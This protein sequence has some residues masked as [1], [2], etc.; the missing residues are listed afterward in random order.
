MSQK[1]KSLL[2]SLQLELSDLEADNLEELLKALSFAE[3][4]N[5]RAAATAKQMD[6]PKADTSAASSTTKYTPTFAE[7]TAPTYEGGVDRGQKFIGDY[8]KHGLGSNN[9]FSG[10]DDLVADY[11]AP[12][13]AMPGSAG[14]KTERQRLGMQTALN[15]YADPYNA[16][17]GTKDS[18]TPEQLARMTPFQR[19]QLIESR[20]PEDYLR[21]NQLGNETIESMLHWVSESRESGRPIYGYRSANPA[22]GYRHPDMAGVNGVYTALSPSM[23]LRYDI[24]YRGDDGRESARSID[25]KVIAARNTTAA[26]SLDNPRFARG[27]EDRM[28]ML[29]VPLDPKR[30]FVPNYEKSEPN[31]QYPVGRYP[32]LDWSDQQFLEAAKSGQ[33]DALMNPFTGEIVVLGDQNDPTNY[34]NETIHQRGRVHTAMSGLG[35]KP[36]GQNQTNHQI[37]DDIGRR[38]EAFDAVDNADAVYRSYIDQGNTEE[39][40]R[41]LTEKYIQ[42]WRNKQQENI[43]NLDPMGRAAREFYTGNEPGISWGEF[44]RTRRPDLKSIIFNSNLKKT[45]KNFLYK[46]LNGE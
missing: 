9:I 4:M 10:G 7:E 31:A 18:Y 17:S 36:S 29:E 14:N 13:R 12:L 8:S 43:A 28:E 39:E 24:L 25:P 34:R 46:L 26:G 23:A 32:K 40:A 21:M 38:G 33:Y 16:G 41:A 30:V 15:G 44:I 19:D 2:K 6:Q 42:Y 1:L 11:M 45:T 27:L 5:R 20:T 22:A 35:L 3:T 37:V